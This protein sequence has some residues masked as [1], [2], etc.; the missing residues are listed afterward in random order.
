MRARPR[1]R[2]RA[3]SLLGVPRGV[4][5]E[6]GTVQRSPSASSRSVPGARWWRKGCPGKQSAGRRRDAERALRNTV[7]VNSPPRSVI[8][9]LGVANNRVAVRNRRAM[10]LA[11]GLAAKTWSARGAREKASNTVA[12]KRSGWFTKWATTGRVCRLV[13][14]AGGVGDGSMGA[15][16]PIAPAGARGDSPSGA[17]QNSRDKILAAETQARHGLDDRTNSVVRAADGRAQASRSSPR[18]H[19]PRRRPSPS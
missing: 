5:N 12:M 4:G 17:G 1:G 16:L 2:L 15:L 18:F 10:S 11:R 14:A 8:M 7:A 9:Y 6:N 19:S 3:A 13:T